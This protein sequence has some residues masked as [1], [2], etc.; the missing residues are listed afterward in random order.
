VKPLAALAALLT[1]LLVWESLP[2]SSAPLVTQPVVTP[3]VVIAPAVT[4]APVAAWT[5]TVLERPLFARDRRPRVHASGV[6]DRIGA[7]DVLP[8]LA[9]TLRSNDGLMAVFVLAAATPDSAAKGDAAQKGATPTVAEKP[10]VVGRDGIVASWTVVDIKDGAATLERDGRV[11][12]L[13]LSY[14]NTPVAAPVV[15]PQALV[16]L[17]DKRTSPFLQP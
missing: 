11:V 5:D 7:R 3:A 4:P 17:H 1:G 8:R 9:G 6:A 13:T 14:A 16:L 15:A 10:V 12:T 2:T